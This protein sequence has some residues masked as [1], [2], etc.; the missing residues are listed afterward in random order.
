MFYF[1]D[2]NIQHY[3]DKLET[4]RVNKDEAEEVST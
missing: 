3:S 4:L 2:A 1:Q